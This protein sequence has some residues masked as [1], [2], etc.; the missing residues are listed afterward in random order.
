MASFTATDSLWLGSWA[1]RVS[2]I[3][4][5]AFP[6]TLNFYF[7]GSTFLWQVSR[8]VVTDLEEKGYFL[9]LLTTFANFLPKE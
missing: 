2:S 7:F 6:L 5:N 8:A 3:T 4:D 9:W 1:L